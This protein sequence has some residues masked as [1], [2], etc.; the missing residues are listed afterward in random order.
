MYKDK[1]K[2]REANRKASQR[3]RHTLT[4]G[5]TKQGMTV[6]GMTRI[7]HIQKELKDPFLIKRIEE[8]ARIFEDRAGRYARALRYKEWHDKRFGVN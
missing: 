6:E 3:R 5:M 7:E 1:E 2:Q 8:G 4:Q